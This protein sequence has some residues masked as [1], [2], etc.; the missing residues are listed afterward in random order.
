MTVGDP[1]DHERL[2]HPVAERRPNQA[3][4]CVQTVAPR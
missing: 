1:A 3:I 2:A 4:S